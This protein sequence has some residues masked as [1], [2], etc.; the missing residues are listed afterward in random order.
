MCDSVKRSTLKCTIH[1]RIIPHRTYTPQTYILR[2]QPQTRLLRKQSSKLSHWTFQASVFQKGCILFNQ[3]GMYIKCNS[4]F[5]QTRESA[6]L[7]LQ[8]Y[9]G[10]ETVTKIMFTGLCTQKTLT[11]R[12]GYVPFGIENKNAS[13]ANWA[14]MKPFLSIKNERFEWCINITCVV[15]RAP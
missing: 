10:W 9:R 11:A 7:V 12:T 8:R 1:K 6:T 14:S 2:T 3:D 13:V 4:R 15:S 5:C